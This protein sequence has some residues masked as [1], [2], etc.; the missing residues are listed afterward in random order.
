MRERH[1]LAHDRFLRGPR[2]VLVRRAGRAHIGGQAV[3][4]LVFRIAHDQLVVGIPQDEGLRNV[5]DRILEPEL[6]FLIEL[7]GELL[8]RDVDDNA[9]EMR[10]LLA[11]GCGELGPGPQPHPLAVAMPHPELAV[12][13]AAL[14]LEHHLG[15]ALDRL[16]LRMQPLRHLPVGE[17]VALRFEPQNVE[18]RSRP[19]DSPARDVPVPKAA[20]PAVER[21]VEPFRGHRQRPVRLRRARRLP[22]ER[23]PEQDE[24]GERDGEQ[25][26]D[27]GDVRPPAAQEI[28]ALLHHHERTGVG[29]E[30]LDRHIGVRS[31]REPHELH[32]FLRRICQQILCRQELEQIFADELRTLAAA[33]PV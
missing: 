1:P 10:R 33:T 14:A 5:L 22:V 6:C 26:R 2:D 24:N 29:V 25:S 27:V 19:E 28:G 17:E 12:E 21:L 4:L 18:H 23:A 31:V 16:I 13:R 11:R 7:L 30:R 9:D 8:L 15:V 20:A 32:S 3:E